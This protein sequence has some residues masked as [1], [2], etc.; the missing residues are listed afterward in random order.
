MAIF[1]AKEN[2]LHGDWSEQVVLLVPVATDFT[3][4]VADQFEKRYITCDSGNVNFAKS[5]REFA[6]IN[7]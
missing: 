1:E 6:C 4:S 5:F 3:V 7:A 2:E